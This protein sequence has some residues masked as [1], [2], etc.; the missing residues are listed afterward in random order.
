VL[1]L[2]KPAVTAPFFLIVLLRPQR[3][4][5]ALLVGCGYLGLTLGAS[6]FQ[7]DGPVELLRNWSASS[8]GIL[9]QSAIKFSNSNLHSWAGSLG[10]PDWYPPAAALC[11]LG[12]SLWMYRHRFADLWVA[13]GVTALVARFY[14]YHGRYD[15]VLIVLPMMTLFR[16]AKTSEWSERE[17]RRARWLLG[18][19]FPLMIAP[20]GLYLL[21]WPWNRVFVGVQSCVWFLILVFLATLT[22][23]LKVTDQQN[24]G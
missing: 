4:Q 16:I 23:G 24:F 18:L 10:I 11:L 19:S 15:D 20:G 1:A 14:T 5:P 2:V 17:R 7:T 12:L 22:R 8:R 13:I 6:A 9:M 3:L 21:P